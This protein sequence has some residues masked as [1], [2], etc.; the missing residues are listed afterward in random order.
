MLRAFPPMTEDTARMLG[1]LQLAYIGDVVWEMLV[2]SELIHRG[3]NVR[4]M[5]RDAISRVNAGAQARAFGRI[6]GSLTEA[7]RDV[8]QRGRNA[9]PHH[10][11]PK[12]QS[13]A[14]YSDATALE[15]LIGYLYLSGQESRLIDLY[16][17]A[18]EESHCPGFSST[19]R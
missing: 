14:D 16:E 4:H 17:L 9:H 1:P 5:H 15:A 12:N 10:G 8:A 18:K 3:L 6:S 19:S 11:T 13:Q 7:E 2:R